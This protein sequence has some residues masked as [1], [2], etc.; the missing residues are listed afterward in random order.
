MSLKRASLSLRPLESVEL[1]SRAFAAPVWLGGEEASARK[2]LLIHVRLLTRIL[3]W[4]IALLLCLGGLAFAEDN[5]SSPAAQSKDACHAK[6]ETQYNPDKECQPGVAA[7][8]S[9]CEILNQCLSD[10][11]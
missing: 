1:D 6:C 3:S 9:P 8:H 4:A 7:M 5:Q 11:N 10:C 2:L